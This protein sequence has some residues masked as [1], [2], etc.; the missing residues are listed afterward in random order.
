MEDEGVGRKGE[1]EGEG[2]VWYAESLEVKVERKF[3]GW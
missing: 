2:G 1:G 3:S